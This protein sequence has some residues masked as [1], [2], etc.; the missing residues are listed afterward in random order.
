VEEVVVGTL[1]VGVRR[2]QGLID[3]N[4]K[5]DAF[6]LHFKDTSKQLSF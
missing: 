1:V 6:D 5:P 4:V 3:G 2:F